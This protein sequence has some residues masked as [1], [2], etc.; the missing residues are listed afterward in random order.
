[1][2]LYNYFNFIY[3]KINQNIGLVI[4]PPASA[5][6]PLEGGKREGNNDNQ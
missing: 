2:F 6:F 1:M 5:P 4:S 3:S